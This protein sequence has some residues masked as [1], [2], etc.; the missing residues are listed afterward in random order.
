MA[1]SQTEITHQQVHEIKFHFLGNEAIDYVSNQNAQV[2]TAFPDIKWLVL[3]SWFIACVW[4]F[5]TKD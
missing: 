4:S 1:T 5:S 2:E 3:L